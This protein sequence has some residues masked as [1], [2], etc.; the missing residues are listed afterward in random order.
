MAERKSKVIMC[1]VQNCTDVAT[2]KYRDV[3]VCKRCFD[4]L[5]GARKKP[6]K[7]IEAPKETW[8]KRT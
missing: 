1:Q 8:K 3:N 7:I 2:T 4:E 6:T 5:T